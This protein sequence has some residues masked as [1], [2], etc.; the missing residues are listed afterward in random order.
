MLCEV[1]V[2]TL[3]L[4][5]SDLGQ[6]IE[7]EVKEGHRHWDYIV[8]GAGPA[9]LQLGYFLEKAKRNYIILERNSIPGEVKVI[10]SALLNAEFIPLVACIIA[11]PT[12]QN[13]HNY[14]INWRK[15]WSHKIQ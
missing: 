4:I 8:V 15:L 5:T 1:L 7:N 2:V 10:Q 13:Q 11:F 3:V 12:N 6:E 9:G 14:L